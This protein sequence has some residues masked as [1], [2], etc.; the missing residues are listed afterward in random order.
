[1]VGF[2]LSWYGHRAT[3]SRHYIC[4]VNNVMRGKQNVRI[5]RLLSAQ[6]LKTKPANRVRY[7]DG[8]GRCA[9]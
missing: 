1:M 7:L 8:D 2:N 4:S 9:A 6:G 3:G 5:K